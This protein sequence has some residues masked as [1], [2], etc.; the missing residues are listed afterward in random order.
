MC[1]DL[2]EL[3]RR[4]PTERSS[5]SAASV[6]SRFKVEEECQQS[7]TQSGAAPSC[8]FKKDAGTASRSG[9]PSCVSKR[10]LSQQAMTHA[11]A[12][13]RIRRQCTRFE[14][15][16]YYLRVKYDPMGYMDLFDATVFPSYVYFS[17]F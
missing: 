16:G 9:M 6:E 14:K 13:S 12:H 7:L 5:R 10:R 15:R 3:C 1:K 2:L 11:I 8:V 4:V 17:F